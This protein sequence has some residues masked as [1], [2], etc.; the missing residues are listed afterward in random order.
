MSR[1]IARTARPYA[2]WLGLT[3]TAAAAAQAVPG[4]WRAAAD[5]SASQT[6]PQVL[7][8]A[9]ATGL[10][11]S[12]A[13]LWIVTSVTVAEVVT[14]S[15][16]RSG[17]ATRRLVL[18]ACGAAVVAG[19]ALPAQASSG[20]GV[21]VLV[22]LP[23]PERAVAPAGPGRTGAAAAPAAAPTAGTYVVRPGD[24]LW[25]IAHAHPVPAGDVE[26]RWRSIWRH[27]RDVVGDDPD[28]IHPG[29]ALRLPDTDAD[30]RTTTNHD[31]DGERR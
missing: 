2:V 25:S 24:S 21:E 18:L 1:G 28:L 17:G 7:V 8:A 16:P 9:C 23:L 29:Q 22:G 6:V 31:Q 12:L 26:A 11:L 4:T 14:D 20:D 3:A 27:N 30:P 19:T 15:V 5:A 13:W 10:A